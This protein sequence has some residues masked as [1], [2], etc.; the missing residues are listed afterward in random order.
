MSSSYSTLANFGSC[1]QA[2]RAEDGERAKDGE[3]EMERAFT[4]ADLALQKMQAEDYVKA[5]NAQGF[6]NFLNSAQAARAVEVEEE[7]EMELVDDEDS[8]DDAKE[9]GERVIPWNEANILS[10]EDAAFL[11]EFE[12]A[13]GVRW[14]V[15]PEYPTNIFSSEGKIYSRNT[16]KLM[17][18]KNSLGYKKVSMY[19]NDGER[20]TVFVHKVVALC[21]LLNPNN[22]PTIDHVDKDRAHNHVV[23]LRWASYKEQGANRKEISRDSH[24]KKGRRIRQLTSDGQFV[25]MYRTITMACKAVGRDSKSM[26]SAVQRGGLCAG[27]R[28]EMELVDDVEGEVWT[29]LQSKH[30]D[31]K[32]DVSELLFSNFGRVKYPNGRVVEP[33]H[34][35]KYYPTI[36]IGGGKFQVHNV[37]ALVFIGAGESG[38]IVNHKNGDKMDYTITNLEWLTKSQNSQHAQDNDLV[39]GKR[40]VEQYVNG[41]WTTFDSIASASRESGVGYANISQCARKRNKTAGGYQWRYAD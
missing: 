8:D 26:S 19:R 1:A 40:R 22:K 3:Q 10:P 36:S 23:N 34:E 16:K 12:D 41:N 17:S 38:Q 28:W 29:E 14:G 33:R 18:Q 37:L 25:K 24:D 27:F 32:V 35:G 9:S 30:V 13:E 6:L 20:K 5:E 15:L 7:E 31:G 2:A 21:L 39:P 4:N 11:K